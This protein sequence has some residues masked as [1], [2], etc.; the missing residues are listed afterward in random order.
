MLK[1]PV[2]LLCFANDDADRP[3]DTRAESTALK[4]ALLLAE[5]EG[6]INVEREESANLTDLKK[7]LDNYLNDLVIF[8]YAGHADST[9]LLL[10][11]GKASGKGIAKLLGQ[12][13]NLQLVFLNACETREQAEA[14]LDQ[15]V[16]IVIATS[17]P[18]GDSL[19][20]KFS[21]AF[22]EA[23][24]RKSS[25]EAAFERAKAYA[26]IEAESS[27]FRSFQF[28]EADEAETQPEVLWS[29]YFRESRHL[30]WKIDIDIK[31][32]LNLRQ[33]SSIFLNK[34]LQGPFVH[35]QALI[36]SQER[37]FA[38]NDTYVSVN[39][40]PR[41]NYAQDIK[42]LPE[43]VEQLWSNSRPHAWLYG[44][45]G[46]G[47]TGSAIQ[48]WNR[49]LHLGKTEKNIPVPVFVDLEEYKEGEENYIQNFISKYYLELEGYSEEHEKSA[50]NKLFSHSLSQEVRADKRIPSV[51][52]FLDGNLSYGTSLHE[53]IEKL[54]EFAG[55]QIICT[56]NTKQAEEEIRLGF[57]SLQIKPL[58]EEEIRSKIKTDLNRF[59]PEIRELV[60]SNRLWLTLF[61][62]FYEI[63]QLGE[64]AD[65]EK[66]KADEAGARQP[67]SPL[68]LG[69]TYEFIEDFSTEGEF[70]WNY[71]ESKLFTQT[72][73]IQDVGSRR[74]QLLFYRFYL[75]HFI[76]MLAYRMQIEGKTE[77]TEE[78]LLKEINEISHHFY[79]AWF[80]KVF[81]E[82]RRDFKNFLLL[83]GDWVEESER[84]A[85][86]IDLCKDFSI[87]IE[88]F[89]TYSVLEPGKEFVHL[90]KIRT[91]R[92]SNKHFSNFL[93]ATHIW[94]NAQTCLEE[95]RL[96][97]T[98]HDHKIEKPVRLMLGQLDRLN[99]NSDA[100]VLLKLLERCRG[101]F[102]QNTLGN[103]IW[104]ILNIWNDVR[105]YLMGLSLVKLDLRGIKLARLSK[106]LS[107]EPY[108]LSSDLSM[109][110]VNWE[111]IF[112]DK[113][114]Y[115]K[116]FVYGGNGDLIVSAESDGS[117][118][119]WD[120]EYEICFKIL[121]AHQAPI[122]QVCLTREAKYII[123]GSE[124][125][126]IRIW[127]Q[128]TENCLWCNLGLENELPQGPAILSL[129]YLPI[130]NKSE[131]QFWLLSS[132]VEDKSIDV[133]Y[134]DLDQAP[135][136]PLFQ[137]AHH[138]DAV[139][140][141]DMFLTEEG[142]LRILAGSW[143]NRISLWS[144]D[145]HN[146]KAQIELNSDLNIHVSRVHCVKFSP[147]GKHFASGSS[148]DTV[149]IWDTEAC[150][151]NFRR[152]KGHTRGVDSLD[153]TYEEASEGYPAGKHK[154]ISAASGDKIIVWDLDDIDWAEHAPRDLSI[155]A[156]HLQTGETLYNHI[157][158]EKLVLGYSKNVHCINFDPQSG[159]FA[160]AT[161]DGR[162]RIW[163]LKGSRFV[164]RAILYNIYELHVQGCKFKSLHPQSNLFV[165]ETGF[166]QEDKGEKEVTKE[167]LLRQY[168]AIIHE[169]DEE[170]W[171]KIVVKM[172][173]V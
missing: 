67:V 8:H 145:T 137:I 65:I 34:L 24:S 110:L 82:Y 158:H 167:M 102:D 135:D 32:L 16:N 93:A 66:E 111:D 132:N 13:P 155:S 39:I 162:L 49:Y 150:N 70:L 9:H 63:I 112:F 59:R 171:N 152:L 173:Y 98:L 107:Y 109:S 131:R 80:L 124:D 166:L 61:Y 130:A 29:L 10:E 114:G 133:W 103:C 76:P 169:E 46:A 127:D 123:S 129:S 164:E 23:L 87:F 161:A 78:E 69:D 58:V 144:L 157:A 19:A 48:L 52:L 50:I 94:Q 41:E 81:P 3:L 84:L 125:G 42:L 140:S 6:L 4:D 56:T 90:Q 15:G 26:E 2:V 99:H 17:Q 74:S 97:E 101:I 113:G 104:N 43:A 156:V 31:I 60:K 1:L 40:N 73:I 136:K 134:M 33:G 77:L 75:R 54:S 86:I 27:A 47:K 83:A 153:F 89:K 53:N 148:D 138:S 25:I 172:S 18:I 20:I 128:H 21:R 108:F 154:L 35:H 139:K 11:E 151:T 28:E 160:Y 126:T 72:R 85:V 141:L 149:I 146:P 37:D 120:T 7:R 165:K 95:G 143:D 30:S 163:E 96:P 55:L 45:A 115:V 92:I 68:T 12:A 119:L 159:K 22:Y 62:E 5:H 88:G 106:E 118:R 100:R 91:Y 147:D 170:I 142:V 38:N 36:K 51:V 79:Q 117:I 122:N 64:P 168:G 71:F 116:D 121:E 105:G 44:A 14:F 57:N